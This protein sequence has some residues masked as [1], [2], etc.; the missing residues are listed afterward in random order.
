MDVSSSTAEA[1]V[2]RSFW[3][4]ADEVPRPAAAEKFTKESSSA[5]FS[6]IVFTLDIRFIL[7]AECIIT[8][9]L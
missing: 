3:G 6:R 7:L 2:F 5:A 4:T 9:I 8:I 1:P